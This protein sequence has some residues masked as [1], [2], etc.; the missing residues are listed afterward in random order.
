MNFH[1]NFRKTEYKKNRKE[2][3]F[4]ILSTCCQSHREMMDTVRSVPY[5]G[6]IDS[7]YQKSMLCFSILYQKFVHIAC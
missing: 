1:Y 4:Y 6:N 3:A 2:H 5:I 7:K